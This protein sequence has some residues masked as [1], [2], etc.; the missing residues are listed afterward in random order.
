MMKQKILIVED[1]IML[2]H[3]QKAWLEE[4]GY[5]VSTAIDEPTARKLLRKE[6]FDLVLSDVRLP[7]GNGI[8][9]LEWLNKEQLKIPFVTTTDYASCSDAVHA[10]KLGAKDYL[11]KP[12]Y[13]ARLLELTGELLK[14]LSR[15]REE[16]EMFKRCSPKAKNVE[17]LA[18]LVA[19]SDMSVLIL[20][21]NGTG[22]ES[23]AQSI[24]QGS[25]RRD[26]PF[27]AVNCGGIPQDI[28]SSL[29]FGHVKGAFTGAETDREGYFGVAQGGTLFLDEIGNLSY[30]LQGLLLRVLQEHV[31]MPVG[32][33]RER[34]ADVRIIAATNENLRLA[35]REGRF[36]ED[37]FY[38]LNEFELAQPSL[39]ECQEDIL[40]LARFFL[41]RLSQKYGRVFTGFTEEAESLLVAYPWPGNIRELKNCIRRAVIISETTLISASDLGSDVCNFAYNSESPTRNSF[42]EIKLRDLE[43]E[44][45]QI[46]LALEKTKGNVTKA[47]TLLGISRTALYGKLKR[48]SL[49]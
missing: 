9:L 32:S 34:K 39:C 41:Q 4:A 1:N 42:N 3:M 11:P 23:I 24:H 31:Y 30:E 16:K 27:V 10:V 20:G 44:K 38:R 43:K 36:R 47:A 12:V 8:A 49:K 6:R 26:M 14:P 25:D 35:I 19:P 17:R 22:K 46:S 28:A 48:Y 15:V 18:R 37:L 40:P 45:M 29:F 2:S 7:V 21:A 5:S 13:R 33:H